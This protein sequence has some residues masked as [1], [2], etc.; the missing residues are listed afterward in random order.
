MARIMVTSALPYVNNLPHLGTLIGCTLSADVFA[1]HARSR[2][3]EVLFV[4]G[5]DEHG[6][7]TE[8]KAREE[9]VSPQE[10]CDRYGRMHK[11]VYDWFNILFDVWGR[12]HTPVQTEI[13]QDIFKKLYDAGYVVERE[14]E[15]LYDEQAKQ[16]LA[17]RYVEGTCPYCGY[18]KARGDQCDGCGKLLNA[19]E[20]KTP[21]SKVSSSKPVIRK[22]KHLFLEL[23]KLKSKLEQ[24]Q[25]TVKKDWSKNTI[26]ITENWM[27]DLKERAITRDLSWG[28]PVP[29]KGYEGKVFYVWFDAPIGYISITAAARNDWKDWW[30]RKD[31][32]LAQFM[33]KDN[34]VFHS[35]IFPGTLLGTGEPWTLV[36]TF[37]TTEFLNME[38]GK[39]SKSQGTGVFGDDVIKLE[40]DYGVPVD[41]WRY[42]LLANRPEN[43]DSTFSWKD[44]Q[45]RTNN[46]L[47]ATFANLVHRTI[48]FS[49]KHCQ[50]IEPGVHEKVHIEFLE[51]VKEQSSKIRKLL[52]KAELRAALQEIMLLARDGN[53]F[54]QERQPWK[55]IKEDQRM[56]A[57]D[58]LTLLSLV[59]DLSILIEPYLP[60]T[61][62]KI[63]DYLMVKELRYRDL[64]KPVSL[65]VKEPSV[66]FNKIE[67]KAIEEMQARFSGAPPIRLV[68]GEVLEVKKHPNAN[69]L[70]ILQVGMGAEKR[71]LVAGLAPYYKAEELQGKR[72]VVVTN[73]EHA[74]LRGETSEGMLLAGQKGDVVGLLLA[75][76]AVPGT[77]L[78]QAG[79]EG[80]NAKLSF[81]D[82]QKHRL[83]A[84]KEGVTIDDEPLRGA[85]FLVEKDAYGKLR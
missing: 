61:S 7:A 17:D 72:I 78:T 69:K 82:F 59:R 33:G 24:W 57:T 52:D 11:E 71:Q 84:T 39:F 77:V 40:K 79:K 67:D 6:T 12:T 16:F 51:R 19:T 18:D 2:G 55:T 30:Q 20:L 32:H 13:T 63:Q 83:E 73:L 50:G 27:A 31:V 26:K 68:V 54:F 23:P 25:K 75:P 76:K 9:G 49:Y 47:I 14:V 66:L 43:S 15:Q 81:A 70:F 42:Y 74:N 35:V 36:K 22:S 62:N 58:V 85:E 80:S 4:C 3:D 5:A 65:E 56:A 46:E 1:R 41:V 64:H 44:F 29:L 10:L 8:T 34:V 37:S 60:G 28:V 45:E 38:G 21:V 53:Q 48:H